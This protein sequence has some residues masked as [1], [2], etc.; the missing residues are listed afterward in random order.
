MRVLATPPNE[1]GQSNEER[2]LPTHAF[3]SPH[4]GKAGANSSINEVTIGRQER[5]MEAQGLHSDEAAV[6]HCSVLYKNTAAA[7]HGQSQFLEVPTLVQHGSTSIL[8]Y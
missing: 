7:G 6:K 8:T 5:H 4:P 1:H 3:A 2:R